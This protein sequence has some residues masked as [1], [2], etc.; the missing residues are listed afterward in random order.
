MF[1]DYKGIFQGNESSVNLTLQLPGLPQQ[2]PTGLIG[3]TY[4][5]FLFE[6][7]LQHHT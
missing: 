7:T 1:I 6:K 4:L 3:I 5:L 2:Q